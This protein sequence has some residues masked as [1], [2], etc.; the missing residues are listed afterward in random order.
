MMN[1][2]NS[3]PGGMIARTEFR[4]DGSDSMTPCHATSPAIGKD[5]PHD[6]EEWKIL[7][8]AAFDLICGGH[9][10]RIAL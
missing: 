10:G 7:R 4:E 1:N 5:D 6:P 2:E 9:D 8:P 3:N